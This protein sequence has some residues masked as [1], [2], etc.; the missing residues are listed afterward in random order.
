MASFKKY[1]ETIAEVVKSVDEKTGFLQSLRSYLLGEELK[2]GKVDEKDLAYSAKVRAVENFLKKRLGDAAENKMQKIFA[3]AEVIG[4]EKNGK[5][6]QSLVQYASLVDEG[7]TRLKVAYLQG[8]DEIDMDDAQKVLADH[9]VCRTASILERIIGFAERFGHG[10][11]NIFTNKE[12]INR[13]IDWLTTA[14]PKAKP[15][16]GFMKKVAGCVAPEVRSLAHSGVSAIGTAAKTVCR[17]VVSKVKSVGGKICRAI[18]NL[19]S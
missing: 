13:G 16:S 7:L 17:T 4:D 8:N 3:T 18:S 19:F 6:M 1:A 9:A 12:T 11:V 15:L 14:C 5:V 10:F 2:N